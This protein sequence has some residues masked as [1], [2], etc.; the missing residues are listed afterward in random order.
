[1][2]GVL[3]VLSKTKCLAQEFGPNLA[4]DGVDGCPNQNF[5]L[6][7]AL[8]SRCT[9]RL[10][11]GAELCAFPLLLGL[12][13]VQTCF[14][15]ASENY[16]FVGIVDA[17]A[18]LSRARDVSCSVSSQGVAAA[19]ASSGSFQPTLS[20]WPACALLESPHVPSVPECTRALCRLRLDIRWNRGGRR[21]MRICSWRRMD[22][23][24]A[25]RLKGVASRK[26]GRP[27]PASLIRVP[28]LHLSSDSL[29][30]VLLFQ[31]DG[32]GSF[33]PV[34]SG[35]YPKDDMLVFVGL[36]IAESGVLA[37]MHPIYAFNEIMSVLARY[38]AVGDR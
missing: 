10:G 21:R 3:F 14:A 33:P 22:G 11:A 24:G 7:I 36:S 35:C 31:V 25:M 28:R 37:R 15:Q 23:L 27:R 17:D 20:W 19:S 32:R 18:H 38:E 9:L 26:M 6:S 5:H 2:S 29:L 1:M 34:S 4:K 16:D 30:Q 8:A 12:R 13:R